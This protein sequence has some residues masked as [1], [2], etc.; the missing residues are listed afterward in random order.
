MV[1]AC[2]HH[3]V[4]FPTVHLRM[5][6]QTANL[7]FYLC[8][9]HVLSL[10]IWNIY[11]YIFKW[12]VSCQAANRERTSH[13]GFVRLRFDLGEKTLSHTSI[14]P[15]QS[16]TMAKDACCKEALISAERVRS[17]RRKY[18]LCVMC[19]AGEHIYIYGE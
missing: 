12:R 7:K 3:K 2:D 6:F 19:R 17:I 4:F 5:V 14:P 18:E 8:T 1:G 10:R 13:H 15:N 16:A 9:D 11:I